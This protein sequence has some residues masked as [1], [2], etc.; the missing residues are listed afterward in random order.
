MWFYTAFNLG[1]T[2]GTSKP[3]V[4]SGLIYDSLQGHQR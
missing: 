3:F 1:L 4:R 2:V